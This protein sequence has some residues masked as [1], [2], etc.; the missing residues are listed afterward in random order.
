MWACESRRV[1]LPSQ[2]GTLVL[3]G[4]IFLRPKAR[5]NSLVLRPLPLIIMFV[6]S[7]SGR[8]CMQWW[9]AHISRML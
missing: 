5:T 6:T 2:E 3:L 4:L 8:L 1:A 7:N 9:Y